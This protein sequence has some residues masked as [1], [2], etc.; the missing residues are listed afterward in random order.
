MYNLIQWNSFNNN[1]ME[2]FNIIYKKYY[3]VVYKN[4]FLRVRQVE[5]TEELTNDVFMKINENLS[6]YD[7]NK[8]SLYTWIINI[9]N[10]VVIDNWRKS[11]MNNIVSIDSYN[12]DDTQNDTSDLLSYYHKYERNTPETKFIN[13]EKLVN[14][15]RVVDQLPKT[16]VQVAR[17]FFIEQ[18]SYEEITKEL[19]MSLSNVKIN[20]HRVRKMLGLKTKENENSN[21]N[22][23]EITVR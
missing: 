18:C 19:N 13:D 9:A 16:Y 1:T 14:F 20:I 7:E 10:N 15:K 17:L 5:I 2:N 4:I 6:K 12:F 23:V 3:K 22:R 21:N 11:K 8:A